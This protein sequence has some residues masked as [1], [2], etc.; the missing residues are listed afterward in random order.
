MSVIVLSSVVHLTVGEKKYETEASFPNQLKVLLH[1]HTHTHTH[2][3]KKKNKKNK[4]GML[5]AQIVIYHFLLYISSY[6]SY[7][8]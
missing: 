4:S 7:S 2:T 8:F 5:P 6:Y 3:H 1:T